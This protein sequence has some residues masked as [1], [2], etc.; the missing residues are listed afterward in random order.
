MMF[1]QNQQEK[2][3]FLAVSRKNELTK[4]GLPG[5]SID[6]GESPKE[7]AIR[8]TFEE[9]GIIVSDCVLVHATDESHYFFATSWHGEITTQEVGIVKWGVYDDFTN[10]DSAFPDHNV[11]A[12]AGL[13]QKFPQMSQD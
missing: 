13:F 4:F 2:N 12:F 1:I 11:A 3:K 8:E 6:P 10:K 5:G 7:A 9:S